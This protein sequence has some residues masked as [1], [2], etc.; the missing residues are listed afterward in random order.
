MKRSAGLLLYRTSEGAID[1]LI[2]HPGG[3][4]WARKDDGAWSIPKGEY[5]DSEDVQAVAY[6][7]FSEELG[8]AAPVGEPLEL[9][10]IK[11]PSGKTVTVF[12]LEGDLDLTGFSSNTFTMAWPPKSGK[13]T[14]F[15][16]ID[17]AEW[18]PIDRARTKLLKG[19]VP[20][21]DLLLAHVSSV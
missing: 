15:P 18:M 16:E 19:Q 13:L 5:D 21:L 12:A 11:Q 6:R 8:L 7:E 3:P 20:F 10:T 14:E 4:F 17:R 2:V 9:G 1:V